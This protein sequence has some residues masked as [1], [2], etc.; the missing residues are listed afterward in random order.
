MTFSNTVQQFPSLSDAN[1]VV[2]ELRIARKL[3]VLEAGGDDS[4]V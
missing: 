3:T 2:G 4:L 1:L